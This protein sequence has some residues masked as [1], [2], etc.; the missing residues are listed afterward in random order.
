[1]N[2]SILFLDGVG[3]Y[4]I[5]QETN[6]FNTADFNILILAN[7][8]KK[9]GFEIKYVDARTDTFTR[10]KLYAIIKSF[11]P[12]KI[13]ISANLDNIEHIRR[14]LIK[15]ILVCNQVIL[16][17]RNYDLGWIDNIN[18]IKIN[19]IINIDEKYSLQQFIDP[20]ILEHF[21]QNGSIK[22]EIS[23]YNLTKKSVV[24]DWNLINN[25]TDYIPELNIG[26]GCNRKCSFCSIADS[27]VEFRDIDSVMIEIEYLLDNGV[28][29]F[30]IANHS[31]STDLSYMKQ[32]CHR[33]I[34]KFKN[35]DFVWSCYGIPENLLTDT[36]IFKLLKEAKLSRIELSIESGSES[37]LKRYNIYS[38]RST[39]IDV[40]N[41]AVKNN[42]TSIVGHLII[43][44]PFESKRTIS[45]TLSL[46]KKLIKTAPGFIEF[47]TSFWYPDY[48]SLI[49]Q[50][51]GNYGIKL[52]KQFHKRGVR[53]IHCMG[54]TKYLSS[55]ELIEFKQKLMKKITLLM[56]TSIYRL[57]PKNRA[58]H[59]NLYEKG[60]TTQYYFNFLSKSTTSLL[61]YLRYRNRFLKFSW[62]IDDEIDN[63]APLVTT[64]ITKYKGKNILVY[65]N[66]LSK[67][68]KSPILEITRSESLMV[69]LA[70]GTRAL[71]EIVS[72]FSQVTNNRMKRNNILKFYKKLEVFDLALFTKVLK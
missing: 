54:G 36:E 56:K 16:L 8:L 44:G 69:N 17:S 34:H 33:I 9:V 37:I 11:K 55:I 29:Y 70:D 3:D 23:R 24:P 41:N 71:K 5:I 59:I 1:M 65:D 38:N 30:H 4:S 28:Q 43:G 47:K 26:S 68:N 19:D 2:N 72:C 15:Q 67:E 42:I 18:D 58:E 40:V 66:L 27:R 35:R 21:F 61:Y 39:I 52:N 50:N 46:V 25:I 32:F 7:I 12:S 13:V 14:L 51:I 31:F 62:E 45:E 63:W 22:Y 57:S 49:C 53:K 20:N 10:N 60:L 6:R 64:K 48:N